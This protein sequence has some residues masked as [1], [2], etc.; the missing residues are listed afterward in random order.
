MLM[1]YGKFKRKPIEEIPSSYLKW[2][3]E[4]VNDEYKKDESLCLAAD[5]EYQFR[6]KNGMHF[7]E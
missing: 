6:E 1:P 5:K 4:N 2:I 7:E 3:A